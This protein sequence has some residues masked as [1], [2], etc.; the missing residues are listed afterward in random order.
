MR[1]VLLLTAGCTLAA[2][3]A[4]AEPSLQPTSEFTDWF[5]K[6]KPTGT[7][8]SENLKRSQ[9][10]Q[11]MWALEVASCKRGGF[12]VDIGAN[13][14]VKISNS[15]ALD[16]LFGWRGLCSDPFPHGMEER[17]C[18]VARWFHALRKAIVRNANVRL[19]V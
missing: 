6:A 13:D 16:K 18:D 5:D 15:W 2:P 10:H 11:D 7:C 12:Y 4:Q 1:G 19:L 17:S 3:V 9:L 8:L 14:G